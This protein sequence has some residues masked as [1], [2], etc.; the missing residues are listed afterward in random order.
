[1]M[2]SSQ[3][4]QGLNTRKNG[5]VCEF[6]GIRGI[7]FLLGCINTNVILEIYGDFSLSM[8][9]SYTLASSW[10]CRGKTLLLI[11]QQDPM[12]YNIFL[13]NS[14]L[15][16]KGCIKNN[17]LIA[18]SF[19]IEDTIELLGLLEYDNIYGLVAIDPYVHSP[20]SPK[21][22][23]ELTRLSSHFRILFNNNVNIALFNRINKF[24]SFLPEGGNMH[25]HLVHVLLRIT[26]GAG[27][28]Y[29]V[30]L[31]KHPSK[32]N[33]EYS[34]HVYELF[35]GGLEWEGQYQLLEWL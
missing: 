8:I 35:G 29:K 25:H 34:G 33:L 27:S 12:S 14:M 28:S 18:R 31:L 17:I 30:H 9:A 16:R 32:P 6:T 22:Y 19:R 1:M 23:W 24:G 10:A 7:D 5:G 4:L 21:K 20:N 26:R 13:L 2:M 3:A 11:S 15:K